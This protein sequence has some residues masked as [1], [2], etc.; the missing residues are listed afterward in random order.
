[1]SLEK[2]KITPFQALF[3][4]ACFIHSSA[5]LSAFIAGVTDYDSWLVVAA[6]IVLCLPILFVYLGLMKLYP[7]KNL[8]EINDLAFGNVPGKVVSFFQIMFFLTLAALNLRDLSLFVKQTIMVK[9]P[10]V[11]LSAVCVLVS[12]IAV[13]YGLKVVTRYAFFFISIAVLVL[14]SSLLFA[15][16]EMDLNNFLPM[17]QLPAMKYVQGVNILLSIPFG[18]LVVFLMVLPYVQEKQK[19]I[20][21]YFLGGFLLGAVMFLL[22]VIRDTAVLG[23]TLS[24]FALPAFETLRIVTLFGSLS[25]LEILFAVVIIILLFFKI[26]LLHYVTVLSTAQVFKMKS[27][28]PL[29]FAV[30]VLMVS[31]GF[32]LYPSSIQHDTSGRETADILWQVFEFILPLLALI[33]GKIKKSKSKGAEA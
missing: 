14:G 15:S 10:D 30:G 11:V 13:R 17:L 9:T 31:Y 33:I 7:G 3:S 20:G 6:G 5:L 18:E 19:P 12:A 26:S 28:K 24:L 23:N 16:S 25:R 2:G 22:V 27:Y 4:T 29:A 1:M 32:T 8:V 21:R